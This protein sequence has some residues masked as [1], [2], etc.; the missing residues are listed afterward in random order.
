MKLQRT[1]YLYHIT[2][3]ECSNTIRL[4]RMSFF[5]SKILKVLKSGRTKKKYKNV[6]KNRNKSP[7]NSKL[8]I[9]KENQRD[10]IEI[11]T[12]YILYLNCIVKRI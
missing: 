1:R 8:C 6:N 9:W 7:I 12:K 10:E 5:V 3:Y 11:S 4:K 2:T